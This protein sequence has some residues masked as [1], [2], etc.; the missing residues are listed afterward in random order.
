MYPSP[1]SE[2]IAEDH[3]NDPVPAILAQLEAACKLNPE[4]LRRSLVHM[5]LR[6]CGLK[7]ML[8]SVDQAN[9]VSS[10]YK[11]NV[12]INEKKARNLPQATPIMGNKNKGYTRH[13][14]EFL[15]RM[16]G[17]D[18][19]FGANAGW[20]TQLFQWVEVLL[21]YSPNESDVTTDACECLRSS[22]LKC[23]WKPQ[24]NRQSSS[25]SRRNRSLPTKS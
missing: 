17:G 8:G 1:H 24:L 7:E 14:R 13:L 5:L 12:H 6:V 11:I 15:Q 2:P 22:S 3:P 25:W 19:S 16:M 23:T 20:S 10:L 4:S 9:I 18:V 21:K